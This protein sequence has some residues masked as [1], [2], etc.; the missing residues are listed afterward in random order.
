MFLGIKN[1]CDS[2]K[3]DHRQEN[4]KITFVLVQNEQYINETA[5][6]VAKIFVSATDVAKKP[7]GV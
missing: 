6:K 4:K 5:E 1:F 7:S 2:L 3:V